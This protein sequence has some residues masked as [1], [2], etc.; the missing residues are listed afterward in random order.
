MKSARSRLFGVQIE[1][2]QQRQAMQQ[3][4]LRSNQR[5]IYEAGKGSVELHFSDNLKRLW[6][7]TVLAAKLPAVDS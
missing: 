5:E 1:Q 6:P 2:I 3:S 4:V 7:H